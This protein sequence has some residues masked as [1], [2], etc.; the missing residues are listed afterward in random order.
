MKALQIAAAT[1]HL[2]LAPGA[3]VRAEVFHSSYLSFAL[4]PGWKC[5]LEGAEWVCEDQAE[6]K[7]K[8][9]II[10]LTAKEQGSED[11]LD[12]YE[13]LL[14]TQKPL[15]DSEGMPMGR[16]STL[17]FVRRETIGD[18]VW[19]HGRQF[20]SEVPN[21]YTDYFATVSDHIAMLVT[22]SAYQENFQTAFERFYPSM[23]TIRPKKH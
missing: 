17:E 14:S 15:M 18:K 6:G 7:Q 4:P 10:I 13:D 2:L 16:S 5:N 12:L 1:L 3:S 9:A 11:R 21:Y 23:A 8:T 20:E 19:V 22:F